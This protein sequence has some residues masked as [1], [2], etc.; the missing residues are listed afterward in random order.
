MLTHYF[1]GSSFG[2]NCMNSLYQSL[3]LLFMGANLLLD[4]IPR[5]VIHVLLNLQASCG[6]TLHLL[7]VESVML[8][9]C[10]DYMDSL[11]HHLKCST[12]FCP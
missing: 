3:E 1:F 12:Q 8:V 7:L 10:Q 4:I 6:Q 9:L 2:F 11:E 5:G